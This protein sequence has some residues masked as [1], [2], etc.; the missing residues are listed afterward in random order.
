MTKYT[1]YDVADWFLSQKTMTPKKL[2][3]MCYYAYSWHLALSNE[4]AE[5][6]S[7]KLFDER[8]EAWVHGPVC[9]E[10]YAKYRDYGYEAI[11]VVKSRDFCFDEDTLDTLNQVL[12]VYGR[13]NGNELESITHQEKPWIEARGDAR[14]LDRCNNVLKDSTIFE[15]YNERL[16]N[17]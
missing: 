7:N 5:D 14:P 3:K 6:L 2:Q 17:E 9:P 15:Y 11:D 8:F 1:V 4:A 13:Y 12:E 10:L 16:A